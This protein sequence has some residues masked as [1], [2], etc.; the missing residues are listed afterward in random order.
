ML[1]LFY[2]RVFE[3]EIVRVSLRRMGGLRRRRHIR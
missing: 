2:S 3:A 1:I